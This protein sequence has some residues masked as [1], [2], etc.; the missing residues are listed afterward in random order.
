MIDVNRLYTT[1]ELAKEYNLSMRTVHNRLKFL[2][3]KCPDCYLREKL[4]NGLP[5]LKYKGEYLNDDMLRKRHYPERR[6][7]TRSL[8]K[9]EREYV[10]PP[11]FVEDKEGN[12]YNYHAVRALLRVLTNSS[13]LE[14]FMAL[15]M[16]LWL[17][18][19]V[20]LCIVT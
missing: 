13:L 5:L 11:V 17:G 3:Y 8:T 2:R 10:P 16:M 18:L 12:E 1:K 7:F 4:P 15:N 14:K 19:A 9:A 6:A 20:Y